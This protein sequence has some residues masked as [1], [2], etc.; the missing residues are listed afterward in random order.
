MVISQVTEE[1][2]PI[3]VASSSSALWELAQKEYP[4]DNAKHYSLLILY[5]TLFYAGLHFK[6]HLLNKWLNKRYNKLTWNKQGE[7]RANVIAPVHSLASVALSVLAMFYVCGHGQSPFNNATCLDTPRY[8]HIW[9]LVN[10]CGYFFMDTINI[11][12]VMQ[13]F[14]T[15]DKQMIG[16]H[17][18]AFITFIS[19][20]VFMNWTVVFGVILLF[21]EVSTTYICLRWVLYTHKLHRTLCHTVNAIFVFFT[22]LFGRLVFQSYILFGTG[23][24]KLF[25]MLKT[26]LVWYKVLLVLLMFMAITVSAMMNVFWMFLIVA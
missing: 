9:A 14:T 6:T 21:V 10:T 15:Y 11:I 22:F 2:E 18:I 13:T 20:L 12:F 4:H 24:P 23:Y 19:T 1:P 26:D 8:L 16:H 25:E 5:C 17:V 3:Y 7:Y